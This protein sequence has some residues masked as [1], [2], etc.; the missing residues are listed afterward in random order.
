MTVLV[1][2]LDVKGLDPTRTDPHNVLEN[3][4]AHLQEHDLAEL[5]EF[6]DRPVE[7]L[8]SLW[9]EAPNDDNV[10][11]VPTVAFVECEWDG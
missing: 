1:I 9:L 2:R 4:T 6:K 3:V 11:G 8:C 10:D 5:T 7:H